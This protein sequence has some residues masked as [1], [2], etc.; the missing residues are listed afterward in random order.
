MNNLVVT[1]GL[2]PPKKNK[3]AQNQLIS[4]EVINTNIPKTAKQ[5]VIFLNLFLRKRVKKSCKINIK[6]AIIANIVKALQV[7]K[8]CDNASRVV[9]LAIHAVVKITID[10]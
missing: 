10:P 9:A 1:I 6:L 8:P 4:K 7:I 3:K 2:S 5:R